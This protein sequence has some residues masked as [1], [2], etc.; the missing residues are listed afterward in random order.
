LMIFHFV[1]HMAHAQ[2]TTQNYQEGA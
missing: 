1:R 2:H